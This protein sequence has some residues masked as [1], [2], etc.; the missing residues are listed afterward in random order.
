MKI[1]VGLIF[2]IFQSI[3]TSN[4]LVTFNDF[5]N[6]VIKILGGPDK[7]VCFSLY[8]VHIILKCCTES[9]QDDFNGNAKKNNGFLYDIE[10]PTDISK[11][12]FKKAT[13]IYFARNLEYLGFKNELEKYYSEPNSDQSSPT[14]LQ[15]FFQDKLN[16]PFNTI[17]SEMGKAIQNLTGINPNIT[18]D[19]SFSW[20]V[21]TALILECKFKEAF[22]DT[23]IQG[24]F[25]NGQYVKYFSGKRDL[26]FKRGDNYKLCGI[27]LDNGL[28]Y[29]IDM[30]DNY[31]EDSIFH[32]S[33]F[34]G[35]KNES[36]NI[37]YPY[38]D[39]K[40]DS[41]D[42][43]FDILEGYSLDMSLKSKSKLK[44][45]NEGVKVKT[46][47]VLYANECVDPNSY[48]LKVNKTHYFSIGRIVGNKVYHLVVGRINKV[49]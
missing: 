38:L 40:M 6:K 17:A 18:L 14:S 39:L 34:S 15:Y 21:A 48:K 13:S 49:K 25:N 10:I 31:N 26:L 37:E 19:G 8:D 35:L 28:Y 42:K 36:V 45:D 1:S 9:C 33:E 3:Y 11:Y 7:N 30:P 29:F 43:K 20:L 5:G 27:P 32:M 2:T 41:N 4:Q 24:K 12:G 22:D 47:T 23:K 46:T 44:V 16:T